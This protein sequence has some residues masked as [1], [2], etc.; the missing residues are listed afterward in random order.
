MNQEE[1][2]PWEYKHDAGEPPAKEA[3]PNSD[4]SSPRDEAKPR[5]TKSISWQASEY[6]EH[7]RN[8]GWY[9][10]LIAATAIVALVVYFVTK[11]YFAAG[12]VVVLGFVTWAYANRKPRQLNYEISDSGF[13]VG[14]KKYSYNTF[15]FF[16]IIREGT[17]TSV[18]LYPVKRF[19]PPVTAFFNPD[20]ESRITEALG[21]HMPYEERKLEGIDR[22]ARRLRL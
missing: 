10:G 15:K 12:I 17:I 3:A 2:S 22:L 19:M 5:V 18:Y 7:S 21:E 4:N 8:S 6:I 9:I 16:S 14:Q 20:D 1:N 13:I 11:D